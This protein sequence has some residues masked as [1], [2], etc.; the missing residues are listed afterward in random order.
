[1]SEGS[2]LG[3]QVVKGIGWSAI[4]RFSLQLIQFVIQIVMAR[5]LLPS[6]YGII[7][8][9]AIFMQL[10]QVFI[11][12]GFANAL[13]QKKDCTERDYSTVFYYNLAVSLIL[14]AICFFIAPYVADFY[15]IPLIVKVMRIQTIALLINAWAVIPKARLVKNV[16]FKIQSKVSLASALI[17]GAAGIYM[18]AEGFGVWALCCQSLLNSLLQVIFLYINV[19]WYPTEAFCKESFS[20][21]FSF[22]SKILGASIISV[23]YNNLY[24]IVIGRRFS[25]KEL[26][27]YTRADQFAVFPS[28][29]LASVISRVAFPVLSR[30]QDN[31]SE[32]I[33]IYR[34]LICYSSFV[35]FPLMFGLVAVARPM[36][37]T[38]LTD[39]WA[40]VV[41]ILQIVSF[42]W[43]FDHLSQ[44][45][46]NLL[47]VKGRSDLVLKLEVIK[48]SIAVAV[49][50]A[51]MPFGLVWMC[52]GRVLYSI[53]AL[54]INSYYTSKM[55]S[56][57]YLKQMRDYIP[58]FAA[59]MVMA[60]I[61]YFI[62]GAVDG[63]VMQLLSGIL[64]GAVI[65]VLMTMLFFKDLYKE[66]RQFIRR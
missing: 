37:S 55:I 11:D 32:L 9:L 21:L 64:S 7:G 49:L 25:A 5:L 66:A 28:N 1:M 12:S 38:I 31:D 54:M 48:K 19:K 30:V 56:Y 50:F 59:S 27:L 20:K 36:V 62:I 35:I 61:V 14:Y 23:I 13:I 43:M 40:D 34:K 10:A 29:N 15:E 41:P 52:W 60:V 2:T 39:K 65:Y 26:G 6:D 53:I 17:S 8:M 58:Y 4:E 24:A 57:G 47:Y 22:G 33:S 16:D 46:L 18:A 51:S 45:N 44:L 63:S 3:K 42:A